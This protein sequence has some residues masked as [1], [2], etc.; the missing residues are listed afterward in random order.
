MKNAPSTSSHKSTIP[1]KSF[2]LIEY[3]E[4]PRVKNPEENGIVV[5]QNIK[6]QSIVKSFS[7]DYIMYLVDDTP[8]TT[9]DAY[10]SLDVDF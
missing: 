7:D 6:R 1:L 10:F 2:I 5:N 3:I 4:E 8:R 9:E